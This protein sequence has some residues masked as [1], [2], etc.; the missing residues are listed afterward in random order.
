MRMLPASS[1]LDRTGLDSEDYTQAAP[2]SRVVLRLRPEALRVKAARPG[3][4]PRSRARFD[5][6]ETRRGACACPRASR[7]RSEART[8]T[9]PAPTIRAARRAKGPPR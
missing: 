3:Y 1:R 9:R 8:A 5:Q 4:N 2:L 6:D 7:V